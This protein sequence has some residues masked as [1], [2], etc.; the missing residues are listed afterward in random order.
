MKENIMVYTIIFNKLLMVVG[1]S[2]NKEKQREFFWSIGLKHEYR[3]KESM[4]RNVAEFL[5][6]YKTAI[7]ESNAAIFAGAGLSKPVGFVNWKDLLRDIAEEI[8]L[9]IDK[10]SDLVSFPSPAANLVSSG[11]VSFLLCK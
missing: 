11:W 1:A 7:E 6:T 10:E 9:N 4:D 8:N 3:R 2:S 5:K